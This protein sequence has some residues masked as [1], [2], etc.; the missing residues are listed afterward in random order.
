MGHSRQ[1]RRIMFDVGGDILWQFYGIAD[2]RFAIEQALGN[3][4]GPQIMTGF[5]RISERRRGK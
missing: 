3:V 2:I 5:V 1:A 4:H